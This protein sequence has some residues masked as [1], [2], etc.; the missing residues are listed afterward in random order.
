MEVEGIVKGRLCFTIK[1]RDGLHI[2]RLGSADLN[3][4]QLWIKVCPQT[5]IF[6]L[7]ACLQTAARLVRQSAVSL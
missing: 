7:G 5:L 4:A 6:R 1:D 2:A 3:F